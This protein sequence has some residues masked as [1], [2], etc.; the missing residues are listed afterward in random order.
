MRRSSAEIAELG[1][2]LARETEGRK[3]AEAEAARVKTRVRKV[4]KE[5]A[6]LE[7]RLREL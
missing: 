2:E 3:A 4:E 1:E 6:E 7:A 5:C